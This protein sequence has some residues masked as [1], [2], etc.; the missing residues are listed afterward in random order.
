[1]F[2]QASSS[3]HSS[4]PH[5]RYFFPLPFVHFLFRRPLTHCCLAQQHV[6]RP[7]LRS[8]PADIV[9]IF[10]MEVGLQHSRPHRATILP[11]SRSNTGLHLDCPTAE[12]GVGKRPRAKS[13]CGRV[14][15]LPNLAR[16]RCVTTSDATARS[17]YKSATYRNSESLFSFQQRYIMLS[18]HSSVFFCSGHV[19]AS[20]LD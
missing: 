11:R 12:A 9:R 4:I 8:L 15:Y 10:T 1:M 3:A 16:T 6:I 5:Q 2:H 18:L 17:P 20:K 19:K 13:V 14:E 7:F